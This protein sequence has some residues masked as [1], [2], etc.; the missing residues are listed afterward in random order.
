MPQKQLPSA[1]FD[2]QSSAADP[3]FCEGC[4]KALEGANVA[5]KRTAGSC[6]RPGCSTELPHDQDVLCP[7]CAKKLRQ[8]RHCGGHLS[9]SSC[10]L[11]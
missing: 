1:A 2:V 6:Q 9:R 11:Q 10:L 8:C 5:G 4:W 3:T 7:P